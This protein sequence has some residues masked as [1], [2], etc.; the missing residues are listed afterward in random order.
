MDYITRDECGYNYALQG[1]LMSRSDREE[2]QRLIFRAEGDDNYPG[3]DTSAH[4]RDFLIMNL[5]HKSHLHLDVRQGEKFV[6]YVNGQYW[7]VY[8]YR[9]KPD[10]SDYTKYYYG[11]DEYHLYFLKLWGGSW[12]E[13]GGQAAW[14][15]WNPLHDF[16]LNNDMSIQENY[17]YVKTKY[18]VTS[19]TDYI[20]TNSFVVCSD[21]INWNVGWWRGIDPNGGHQKWAYI[22]WDEDATFGHYI[23]YTGIPGQNP[24]VSPCFPEGI[25]A[26]PEDH[27]QI[28]NALMD[29]AEFKDYYV[30][31]YIDLLNTVYRPDTMIN[32]L[33]SIE[34]YVLPEMQ[35]HCNRWG[36]SVAEWQTNVQKI[37]NFINTR[38]SIIPAGLNSCYELNGPYEVNF[39]II[40]PEAGTIQVN[41]IYPPEIP[42]GG[43]YY[44]GI[45]TRLTAEETNPMYEFDQWVL[46]N[47]EVYPNNNEKQVTME[48]TTGDIITAKFKLKT[49]ADSL[50]INEINYNSS[51][52]VDP[53]DWVEFYNPHEYNL[54]LANWEFKDSDDTHIFNFP[55]NTIIQPF[56]YLVL[57]RDSVAF[58]N[59]FPDIENYLGEM[60]FGLSSNGE[61]IRLFDNEGALIDTVNYGISDPWPPEPN[62]NG[63]TLE[64][65]FWQY[66][67]AIASNWASSALNGTPGEINSCVVGLEK[68]KSPALIFSFTIYPNP[69][70]SAG[71]L[72]VTSPTSIENAK[73]IIC[74]IY[75]KEIKTIDNINFDRIEISSQG[76]NPGIF[77]CKFIDKDNQLLGT[78]KF[79]I[80]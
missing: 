63:P 20:I 33:D 62:G 38:Y 9:E 46:Y 69:F 25:T 22:L 37:R 51:T 17:E 61:L 40:P 10:D 11:Q 24:Y 2:F 50:V 7:G 55:E 73:V 35:A 67:N 70:K 36:G 75:G 21:W 72:Q 31:R 80:Q 13:Y 43:Y 74:N 3:I 57:C 42:W 58:H 71:I 30:S 12:A 4:L 16:I 64:L 28:L 14:N 34:E 54:N 1:K 78:E 26:D 19:L 29:N 27:I 79:I 53:G 44:G 65:K 23:N 56:G 8:S 77:I 66:D 41:S 45:T 60:S 52:E 48:F 68:V 18:D 32:F 15:D 76:L 6:L 59:V 49:F 47:H 5:A 39:S